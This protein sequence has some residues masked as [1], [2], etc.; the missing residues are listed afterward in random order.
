MPIRRLP[1]TPITTGG[2]RYTRCPGG[3]VVEV[4]STRLLRVFLC[5]A[6][7]DKPAVRNLY[8]RLRQDGFDPWLD[9]E[10]L[11]PGQD[12]DLEIRKAVRAAD[13]VIVCLSK[14]SV[15]KAGYI[16]REIR[17]S[18]E[19]AEEQPEGTIFL[20]PLRFDDCPLPDRLSRWHWVD[21]FVGGGYTRLSKSLQE[22]ARRLGLTS[23]P[24]TSTRMFRTPQLPY[25]FNALEPY[26]DGVSMEIHYSKHHTPYTIN[27]N[28]ALQFAP[29]L[30]RKRLDDLLSDR[31]RAVPDEIKTAIRNNGGGHLNHS[32]FWESMAP[33]THRAPNGN[34]AR[35]IARQFMSLDHF[36]DMFSE[37]ALR[38]F[39]SGWAWL[40]LDGE[41]QL[42]I[43]STSNQDSP[44][45]D[46]E[47][48]LLGLDLWE[49]AYYLKYQNRRAEYIQAWWH[50]VNW[51]V[52]E[53]RFDTKQPL[54][55]M[56]LLSAR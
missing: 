46:G 28:K 3:N 1:P 8:D 51:D 20:I 37:T 31:C 23:K 21:Y 13:V 25:G 48:P 52:V 49:H 17:H 43:T 41:R 4:P 56:S 5:H 39:G 29:D 47:I 55:D 50:L 40:V 12:W 7:G 18:L 42:C 26:I 6:S 27:L 14:V 22:R 34:L 19:V 45:M 11:L 35:S 54:L 16:Q 9:A 44:V 32:M 10:D 2:W 36:K 33:A 38:R 15:T 24:S 30:V 53:R